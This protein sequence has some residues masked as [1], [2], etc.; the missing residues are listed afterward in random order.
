M[1]KLFNKKLGI[2]GLACTMVVSLFGGV[3]FANKTVVADDASAQSIAENFVTATGA[4]VSGNAVN[5]T[6][7]TGYTGEIPYI[8]QGD[9]A[10]NFSF[11]EQTAKWLGYDFAIKFNVDVCDVNG[12]PVF[13]VVYKGD[14][15]V[16]TQAYV[17]QKTVSSP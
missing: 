3:L 8:L 2:L 14:G 16:A 11:T 7:G 1:K 15:Q 5:G 12:N 13:S 10:L 17:R 9:S 4:T 6:S